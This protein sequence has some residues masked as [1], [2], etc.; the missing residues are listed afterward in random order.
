MISPSAIIYRFWTE[1]RRRVLAARYSG[2]RYI[3]CND[4]TLYCNYRLPT[5][6]WY[7][8]SIRTGRQE[9][10]AT[11]QRLFDYLLPQTNGNVFV[12]IGAH[13]GWYTAFM[14]SHSAVRGRH[15]PTILSLEADSPS[16]A[17]LSK[18][19]DKH[20]DI[21]MIALHAALH[22]TTENIPAY[23]P[24]A[25]GKGTC[26]HTYADTAGGQDSIAIKGL[27]LDDICEKWLE[28]DDKIAFIKID[29]DGAEPNLFA[30]GE[31]S[32]EKHSPFI[33]M[34]F[35]PRGLREFGISPDDYLADL[36]ERFE[37]SLC[38]SSEP[39]LRKLES[40]RS[41]YD[42]EEWTKKSEQICDLLLVS[43]AA[44]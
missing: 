21:R 17:C 20:T 2:G 10:F 9:H 34:E 18:T 28:P 38:L 23:L 29:I 16:Y 13:F 39:F 5:S 22:H 41:L 4:V 24:A 12:D 35:W 8:Q 27:A 42:S 1:L 25:D 26:L 31:R 11:D 7:R 14:A 6:V 36:L 19:A 40:C 30:G 37:V 33:H 15:Q 44:T 32:L 3:T 43:R